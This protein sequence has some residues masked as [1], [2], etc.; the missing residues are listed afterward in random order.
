MDYD[1]LARQ[2]GGSSTDAANDVDY[3]RLAAAHGG[4]AERQTPRPMT[5]LEAGGAV[6]SGVNRGALAYLPGIV[7]DTGANA[8]DLARAAYGYAGNK[9]GLI[10]PADMPVP[11][12]RH[13]VVGSSQWIIDQF[14]RNPVTAAAINNPRPDLPAARVLNAGGTALGS[15]LAGTPGNMAMQFGSGALGQTMFEATGD[16]SLAMLASMGPQTVATGAAGATRVAM[17]GGEAGRRELLQRQQDFN[18]AGVAPTVGL[19]TGNRIPL[20][21]ESTLSRTP[22]AAGTMAEK[23]ASI[24]DQL[25]GTVNAT[26]DNLSPVYGPVPAGDALR[27][28]IA[29]Y[30]T[31][32]NQIFGRMLDRG[33]QA[34]PPDATFPVS[35]MLSRGPATLPTVPGA[36]NV[37]AVL[38]EPLSYTQRLMGALN[39]DAAPQPPQV[40]PSP[41]VGPN[42]LPFTTTLPG[43]SGGLPLQALRDIRT[44]TGIRA[45]PQNPLMAD[46]NQGAMKALYGASKQD[47]YNAAA[48]TDAQRAATGQPPLVLKQFQRADNFNT[49]VNNV[50]SKTLEPIYRA[51][52]NAPEGSYRRFEGDVRNSGTSVAQTMASIPLAVRRTVTATLIDRIGRANP[53]AQTAEG[54]AFSSGTFLTNWNKLTP[55]AKAGITLGIPGG[56]QVRQNLDAVAKAAERIKQA[57]QVYANPSGTAGAAA[58]LGQA[59]SLGGS[60]VAFATGHPSLGLTGLAAVLGTQALARGGAYAMTS[61][62]FLKWLSQTSELRSDQVGAHLRRLSTMANASNDPQLRQLSANLSAELGQ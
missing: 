46:A 8:I 49:A 13:N 41:I 37:S 38:T 16:P 50:L 30:R 7:A 31:R 20:A 42:G 22:G 53:G 43:T 2:Y 17:R 3:D 18:A 1:A 27:Q 6:S 47:L 51:G 40:V 32:G 15:S 14:Q 45:F 4:T 26:R 5:A 11:L 48:A 10:K 57:G 35:A 60:A 29:D 52:D 28:G 39:K 25:Q 21:I 24:Q 12:N 58:A 34:V 61:P 44:Q 59:A 36:P 9:L 23:A 55:D 56:A 19:A 33:L 54:D 62:T